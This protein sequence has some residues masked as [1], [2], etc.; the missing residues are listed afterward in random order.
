[1]EK[2]SRFNYIKR[3]L[4]GVCA[5]TMLTGLCAAPAFAAT[6]SISKDNSNFND[7]SNGGLS[8]TTADTAVGIDPAQVDLQISATVPQG[9][10]VGIDNTG[11]L[12]LPTDSIAIKNTST[13]VPLV[14]TTVTINATGSPVTLVDASPAAGQLALT[15]ENASNG[16][17]VLSKGLKDGTVKIPVQ[18]GDV[19]GSVEYKL[20][21]SM[22][23]A[24]P[25]LFKAIADAQTGNTNANL[26]SITWTVAA[27]TTT[28]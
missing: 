17:I 19:A 1:M 14:L 11:A 15:L 6:G 28:A 27:D 8:A 25:A 24:T 2:T 4:V 7:S 23:A 16:N 21:G 18:S 9:V 12:A 10:S 20:T 5:A 26:V 3:G 22:G 13:I